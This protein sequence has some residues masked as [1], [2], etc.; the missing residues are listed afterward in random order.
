LTHPLLFSGSLYNIDE[1][2][3]VLSTIA[4]IDRLPSSNSLESL[5]MLQDA[6]DHIE[7]YD[8]VSTSYKNVSKITY[9][10]I[11]AVG[12]A[13]TF[14]AVADLCLARSFSSQ[15]PIFILGFI[16]TTVVSYVSYTNPAVRW[17]QLR[18]AALSIESNIWLFRTRAGVYRLSNEQS[19]SV[20]WT[21][22][23]AIHDVKKSVLDGADVKQTAF[24]GRVIPRNTHGQRGD[25]SNRIPNNMRK[26][27][28][29]RNPRTVI[30]QH[31]IISDSTKLIQLIF[32]MKMKQRLSKS[33]AYLM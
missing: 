21:L 16:G 33:K 18:M 17:Q 13:I 32:M 31:N 12:I 2:K 10:L 23:E 28:G 1:I 15:M 27:N 6:W 11:L 19:Q 3:H 8:Q 29:N 5:R 9:L 25:T 7:V 22:S 30:P 26:S 24:Y 14:C 4:K 20:E